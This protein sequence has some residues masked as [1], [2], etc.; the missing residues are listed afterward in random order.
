L[1]KKAR[2][3][4]PISFEGLRT[5]TL[6]IV[7]CIHC[8]CSTLWNELKNF[9]LH[10]H[11]IPQVS[12][13]HSLSFLTEWIDCLALVPSRKN[14][15]LGIWVLP[16]LPLTFC[17]ILCKSFIFFGPLVPLWYEEWQPMANSFSVLF[18]LGHL[19]VVIPRYYAPS[20]VVWHS[21]CD[22]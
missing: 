9:F 17:V 8:L 16:V 2:V 15:V 21:A 20:L 13:W 5:N 7:L 11:G 12:F 4:S 3:K 6:L 1:E 18:H 10:D 19:R 14:T 22:L